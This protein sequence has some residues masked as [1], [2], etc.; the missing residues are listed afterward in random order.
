MLDVTDV[1]STTE[2]FTKAVNLEISN[3]LNERVF[4]RGG[5][6]HHWIVLRHAARPGLGRVGIEMAGHEDL[7][8]VEQRLRES[9]IEVESGAAFDTDR[10][11]CY[12][13]FQDPSGNPLELYTD[14]VSMPMAPFP[15]RVT[16]EDIRNV[17]L[18][19]RDVQEAC[20][21]YTRML[22]MEVSDWVERKLVYLRFGN[23]YHH[24]LVLAEGNPSQGL[25]YINFQVPDLHHLMRAR[26]AVQLQKWPLV[27]DLLKDGPSGAVGFYFLNDAERITIGFCFDH[28]VIPEDSEQKPRIF[29]SRADTFDIWLTGLEAAQE[30]AAPP[31]VA[32][33][34]ARQARR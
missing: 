26:S 22:G 29:P 27:A 15:K 10:I 31:P 34:Q 6:Q 7:E 11:D 19:Q 3:R 18:F 12:L 14:M 24:G 13:R 30:I 8:A 33:T 21:F 20:D 1:V 16:V 25:G 9:G 2:F 17:V 28:A 32:H 23:G 5:L 4:L